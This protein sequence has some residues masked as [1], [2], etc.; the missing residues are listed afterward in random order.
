MLSSVTKSD[1]LPQGGKL[2]APLTLHQVSRG[3]MT[4]VVGPYQLPRGFTQSAMT[5]CFALVPST[6]VANGGV[7]HSF[8]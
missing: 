6:A 4:F 5:F 8:M 1:A 7:F 2:K 3:F